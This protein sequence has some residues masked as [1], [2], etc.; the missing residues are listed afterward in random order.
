MEKAKRV[1]LFVVVLGLGIGI[2]SLYYFRRNT[3]LE[4]ENPSKYLQ[5]FKNEIINREFEYIMVF[6]VTQCYSCIE[7]NSAVLDFIITNKNADNYLFVVDP[8]NIEILEGL[9]IKENQV[10]LFNNNIL[11]KYGIYDTPPIFYHIGNNQ[12]SIEILNKNNYQRI[13]KVL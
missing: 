3:Q 1:L 11:H 6:P 10:L 2:F 13:L 8:S 12:V 5:Y 7:F 4:Q 9:Q